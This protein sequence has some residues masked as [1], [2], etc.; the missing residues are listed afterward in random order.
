MVRKLGFLLVFIFGFHVQ[1][2]FPSESVRVKVFDRLVS[3][4]ERIDG[5]G[6]LPR[7]NRPEPWHSTVRQL[8]SQIIA[9]KTPQE[10]GAVFRKLDATYPN[11]HA[12]VVLADEYE[13]ATYSKK[14][15]IAV[16]FRAEIIKRH[17]RTFT[18]KIS[19]I[20]SEMMKEFKEHE[21][22][23]IGDILLAINDRPLSQWSKENFIYCKFPHREQCENNIFDNFRKGLLS[24]KAFEPLQYTFL[25]NGREWKLKIPVQN[26]TPTTS[27]DNQSSDCPVESDRYE[28]FTTSYKGLNVCAFESP[29]FP[30]TVVLRIASFS[31]KG[32]GEGSKIKSIKDEVDKFYEY[33]WQDRA[34]KTKKL[35]IDLLDNGGGDTPVEWYRIFYSKPFQEMYVRFKKLIELDKPEV[36]GNLFIK[37]LRKRFGFLNYLNQSDTLRLKLVIFYRR[38][39]NF[40]RKK[41][42]H[43]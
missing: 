34:P 31:Y 7:E 14:P 30:G 5:E 33:F 27:E 36:R 15:E 9:A 1:A 21:R 10:F 37:I 35:I 25:R 12:R 42:S 23:A 18:Y 43:V 41:I 19:N 11:L 24:W 32:L 29:R 40:V 3:E 2:E 16:R 13:P 8:R 22:P 28:A 39:P 26:P 6:L 17:Q 4:M 20:N 38:F